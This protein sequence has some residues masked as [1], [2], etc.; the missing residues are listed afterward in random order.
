M[1]KS[2]GSQ[3]RQLKKQ[4]AESISDRKSIHKLLKV[5]TRDFD[6]NTQEHSDI[7]NCITSLSESVTSMHDELTQMNSIKLN[8]DNKIYTQEGAFREL[9]SAI[10]DLNDVTKVIKIKKTFKESFV[11]W[12]QNTI[13]GRVFSTGLGKFI[14]GI[15]FIF[16]VLAVAHVLGADA[17]DPIELTANIA[18]SIWNAV[19]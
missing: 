12:K 13:M 11:A 7:K 4:T 6:Q 17:L 3:V 1:A 19:F 5:H 10:K 14:L 18:K 16:I 15:I 8:G 2:M 9:Y